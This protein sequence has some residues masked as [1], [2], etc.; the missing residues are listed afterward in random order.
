MKQIEIIRT[1]AQKRCLIVD[2]VP[3]ARAQ[4]KRILVDFGTTDTDA[5]GNAEEA[6]D[7]CQKK[8]YDIVI[9]DYSLGK[10]RSGQ[11]LLEELRF[12]HLL[13][14]TSIFIM[15]TAE[16][17]SHYVLHTLEYQPDDFLQKPVSRDSLRP[18]LDVALLKNEHLFK[19]KEAID[20]GRIGKAIAFAED[21]ANTPHRF[22][23]DAR[24]VLA[25]LY[26]KNKQADDAI[27][28]YENLGLDKLPLWAELGLAKAYFSKKDYDR[29]E[30]ILGRII[31]QNPYFIEAQDLLAKIYELTH[32]AIQSQQAL[33]NAVKLSP[34]SSTRQRE[35][36]RMSLHIEDENTSIHAYR[37]AI[38]HSKNS[39]HEQTDDHLNL[40]ESL[41]KLSKKV[42]PQS[43]KALITEAHSNLSTAERK[44]AQHPIM[45]M[46]NRLLEADLADAVGETPKVDHYVNQALALHR[47]MRYSVIANTSVQ[48]CI[49]CAKSFMNRGCYDEGD[50]IL[51][52]LARV[53]TDEEFA[54]KIDRLLRV[55]QTQEGIAFAAKLNKH[56]IEHYEKGALDEAISSFRDVLKELPNHI[57]L[58]LN[59]VQALISKSKT[60]ELDAS[61]IDLVQS[62][63]QRIGKI[64]GTE[65]FNNRYEYLHK[66]YMRIK[67]PPSKPQDN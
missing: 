61:E 53:N 18:R 12:Q 14:N 16:N 42:E 5:V 15:I 33:I 9:S 52:E 64:K 55:P 46:R 2:S 57:G 47:N 10:G 45:M 43:A 8:S 29:S 27:F 1:Y 62:S 56:G 28:V 54:V 3:D 63:F 66:R 35:L 50:A 30:S 40:A 39:C 11:Q 49:D 22:Q 24:R 48:L 31:A 23:I 65:S 26:L 4:M 21:T 6:I 44:N 36:G 60:Q 67:E 19:I 37:S 17:S 34:R 13:K 41:V 7:L 38:K 59:L 51:Q 20:I 32:R 58:N 25:E